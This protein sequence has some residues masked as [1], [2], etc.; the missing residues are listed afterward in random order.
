[1]TKEPLFKLGALWAKQS[2]KGDYMTGDVTVNGETQ[3]VV[4]FANRFAEQDRAAGKQAPD[5]IVY[6]STPKD[7]Q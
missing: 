6:K 1:M 7:G 2:A 5:W 4:I 3:K